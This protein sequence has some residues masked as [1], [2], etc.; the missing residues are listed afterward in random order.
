MLRRMLLCA[1]TQ[2]PSQT[3][4]GLLAAHMQACGSTDGASA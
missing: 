3:P 2:P 4:L 1:R